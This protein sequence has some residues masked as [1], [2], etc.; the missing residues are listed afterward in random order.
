MIR[1]ALLVILLLCTSLIVHADT[2]SISNYATDGLSGWSEKSFKGNTE[3]TLVQDGNRKVVKAHSKASASGLFKK[4]RL[5]PSRY[6]YLRWSWKIAAIVKNGDERTKAG[7][8]YAARVYVIF[9]GRFFWQTKAINYIW[10]NRLS[11]EAYVPNAFTANAMMLAVESGSDRAGQWIM[12]ERDI[13]AD[14]RK[15]F[16]EEPQEVGAIAIMTD[17]DNT[18]AEATA[19]YTDITLSTSP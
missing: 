16:G 5:D 9:P 2:L 18:G 7:D 12:E 14:Y 13:L 17:T 10:A 4:V 19:W 8:D 15:L 1:T 11:R 6:R 3:Y